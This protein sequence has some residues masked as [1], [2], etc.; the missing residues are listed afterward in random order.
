M[1]RNIQGKISEYD[2]DFRQGTPSRNAVGVFFEDN[3]ILS[4]ENRK[5]INMNAIILAAEKVHVCFKLA[6]VYIVAY[7]EYFK[8]RANNFNA[9]LL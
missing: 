4:I 6:E 9:T 3:P 8:Y 7:S 2:L 5:D 1:W